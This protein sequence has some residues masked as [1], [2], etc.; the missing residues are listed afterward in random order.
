MTHARSGR[1][2]LLAG[3]LLSSG[4]A[5]ADVVPSLTVSSWA[6]LLWPALP[7]A[8]PAAGGGPRVESVAAE[9]DLYP[10]VLTVRASLRVQ[11]GDQGAEEVLAGVPESSALLS[12]PG[13]PL[14]FLSVWV[15]GK[16]VAPQRV[17][18]QCLGEPP[19]SPRPPTP[20]DSP[21]SPPDS[22][23]ALCRQIAELKEHRER[24]AREDGSRFVPTYRG[25]ERWW[26]W[27]FTLPPRSAARVDLRYL[28]RVGADA[29]DHRSA[30]DPALP[31]SVN[32][33]LAPAWPQAE[34]LGGARVALRLHGLEH[35]EKQWQGLPPTATDGQRFEWQIPPAAA[36]FRSIGVRL[37]RQWLGLPGREVALAPYARDAPPEVQIF[38]RVH[39]FHRDRRP[40]SRGQWYQLFS[41][42]RERAGPGAATPAARRMARSLLVPLLYEST[43][44][45]KASEAAQ[46]CQRWLG[47]DDLQPAELEEDRDLQPQPL[48]EIE[49]SPELP[50]WLTRG[51]V[52]TPSFPGVSEGARQACQERRGR[53]WATLGGLL[54][55]LL[56]GALWWARR[57][58]CSR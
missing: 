33:L 2:L 42:L 54:I 13:R 3:L 1:W 10:T 47:P 9:L 43:G 50:S 30:D 8:S 17:R 28:Q 52:P 39:R 29:G 25:D 49:A 16:P 58:R 35:A 11:S 56:L 48:P 53:R 51:R 32:Y 4:S 19:R 27:R 34:R 5:L 46:A 12:W 21:A 18:T 37:T 38:D 44:D 45:P 22:S 36:S 41:Y 55:L 31:V 26:L 40:P 20:A 15:D 24:R 23:D 7:P 6:P 57:A 14:L